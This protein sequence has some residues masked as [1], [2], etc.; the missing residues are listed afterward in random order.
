MLY[1]VLFAYMILP[2]IPLA[3]SQGSQPE[4][5]QLHTTT[6]CRL[7]NQCMMPQ[8][9][10]PVNSHSKD[11]STLFPICTYMLLEHL[12]LLFLVSECL[13]QC[14]PV[15]Q[16]FPRLYML[17]KPCMRTVISG[18]ISYLVGCM[19]GRWATHFP[20]IASLKSLPIP[21]ENYYHPIGK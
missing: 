11:H 15:K 13:Y 6:G 1:E 12:K 3:S 16:T 9:R 2:Y 4:G 7:A 21:S 14:R 19:H 10:W 18:I 17:V 8:S 5:L 20:K